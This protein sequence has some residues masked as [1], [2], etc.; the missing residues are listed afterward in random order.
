[1]SL[2][3]LH[4][5]SK[6]LMEKNKFITLEQLEQPIPWYK[7]H[8]FII[9][10][11]YDNSLKQS[12][13]GVSL[14]KNINVARTIAITESIERYTYKYHLNNSFNDIT[15]SSKKYSSKFLLVRGYN[16]YHQKIIIPIGCF[17]NHKPIFLYNI[18][19][20]NSG[21]AAH[22]NY[23]IAMLNSLLELI[24]RHSVIL[25]LK[26]MIQA[27]QLV[28]INNIT[29]I[30]NVIDGF[31]NYDMKLFLF[32]LQTSNIKTV[33]AM[34]LNIKKNYPAICVGLGTSFALSKAITKALKE[35]SINFWT[36]YLNKNTYQPINQLIPKT[37][38]IFTDVEYCWN[39]RNIKYFYSLLH[40]INCKMDYKKIVLKEKKLIK[41]KKI[42]QN[43]VKNLT[44]LKLPLPEKL[45]DIS[46]HVVR[47]IIPLLETVKLITNSSANLEYGNKQEA[48]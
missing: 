5:Y 31:R 2:K 20:S 35:V 28:N 45:T 34:A 47:V 12:I 24:E 3:L 29:Q 32:Y 21:F 27:K 48:L 42:K 1:M 25:L 43:I 18:N 33:I 38:L 44:F 17:K 37:N 19:D 46:L 41:P 8:N 26:S 13:I 22:H 15:V 30:A 4:E 16:K 6:L 11:I 39:S 7:S 23:K 36:A 10:K 9:A 40:K 14:D